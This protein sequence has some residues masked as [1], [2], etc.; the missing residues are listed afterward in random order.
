MFI[1]YDIICFYLFLLLYSIYYILCSS[2]IY[3]RVIDFNYLLLCITV[4]ICLILMDMLFH[5]Y[6]VGCWLLDNGN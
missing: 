6:L 4:I 1:T 5:R 2:V 3:Y